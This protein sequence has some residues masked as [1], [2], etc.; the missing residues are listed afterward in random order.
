MYVPIWRDVA[1]AES[2]FS[3]LYKY[4]KG[5]ERDIIR[6][7]VSIYPGYRVRIFNN[8]RCNRAA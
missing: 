4:P 2:S 7:R 3:C 5:L 8:R 1:K 6:E